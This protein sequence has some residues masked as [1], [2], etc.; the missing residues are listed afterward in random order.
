MGIFHGYLR[1]PLAP[2]HISRSSHHLLLSTCRTPRSLNSESFSGAKKKFQ[3]QTEP[4]AVGKNAEGGGRSSGS[5]NLAIVVD[6]FS[7]KCFFIFHLYQLYLEK[8]SHLIDFF[9]SN[10]LVQPPASWSSEINSGK[11]LTHIGYAWD[12]YIV[13]PYISG[14]PKIRGPEVWGDTWSSGWSCWD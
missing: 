5:W 12:W 11:W 14:F 6:V 9:F 13:W 7:F 1:F 10:G 8:W 2:C 4:V 3:R